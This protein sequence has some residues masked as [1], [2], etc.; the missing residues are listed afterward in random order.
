MPIKYVPF[1]CKRQTAPTLHVIDWNGL[2][3]QCS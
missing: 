2:V 1:M 3:M